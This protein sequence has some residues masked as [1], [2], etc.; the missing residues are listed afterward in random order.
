MRPWFLITLLLATPALAQQQPTDGDPEPG[1][2]P[3]IVYAKKTEIDMEGAQVDGTIRAPLGAQVAGR[4][5]IA[6]NPL[7]EMRADFDPEL[8]ESVRQIR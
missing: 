5:A 4:R 3:T 2:G 7:I 1:A 6:W 8:A